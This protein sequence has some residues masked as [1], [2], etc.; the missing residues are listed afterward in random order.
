MRPL[1]LCL[2]L[3]LACHGRAPN[4][5]E[6]GNVAQRDASVSDAARVSR[7]FEPRLAALAV[8]DD[9]YYRSVL[10]TWT[11]P[12]QVSALRQ[13]HV[14]LTATT[15]TGGFVSPFLRELAL[16]ATDPGSGRDV[17]RL[18]LTAPSLSRRRYAWPAP[19]ATS[20]GLG[21]RTYGT[22]LIRIALRDDAWIG[23]FDPAVAEPFEF[24]DSA[25]VVVSTAEVLA[26]PERLGAI[27][28]IRHER[29]AA[30]RE[31]V[32]CNAAAISSWSVATPEI[33]AAVDADLAMLAALSR[34]QRREPSWLA[35]WHA[36]LA[37]DTARYQ[38][39]PRAL[40]TIAAALGAYD[41]AGEPLS[42]P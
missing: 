8:T 36:A 34:D 15:A 33:R 19:F 30:I 42:Y 35:D 41:P 6:L 38:P 25:N 26:H 28:H 24:V 39:T 14:L 31:Y 9:H 12:A 5:A 21:A 18:L 37:F 23:R 40:A 17:A 10:Y 16:F 3:A 27:F 11:S 13:S 20:L 29:G 7:D 2:A 32:I 4:R 1:A 22:S